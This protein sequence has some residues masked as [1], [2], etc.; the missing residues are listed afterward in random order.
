MN[1]F[2]ELT[3]QGVFVIPFKE[4]NEAGPSCRPL[5]QIYDDVNAT[6]LQAHKVGSSVP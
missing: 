2:A 6:Y 4:K 5:D 3:D 1:S